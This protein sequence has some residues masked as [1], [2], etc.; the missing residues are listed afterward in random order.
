M[1]L[2]LFISFFILLTHSI[3]YS[4]KLDES[5]TTRIQHVISLFKNPEIDKISDI[6][7]FPLKREHPIPPIRNKQEFKQRF[8]QVFDDNLIRIIANSKIRQWSD[9]GWRGIM[10]DN[11]IIWMA[12]SDGVITSVNYQSD[13][14]EKLKNDLIN[15]EKGDLHS[16]LKNYEKPIYK[17]KTKNYYIRID[18]LPNNE[19]RYASWKIG[20]R[21]SAKPDIVLYKGKLEFQGSGGNHMITFINHKYTYIIF[22]NRIGE[23]PKPDISLIVEKDDEVILSQSGTLVID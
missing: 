20:Q 23:S 18:E 2:K 9:V 3:V 5:K 13:F 15:K 11:G 6:I 14:E 17:I 21:E 7:S 4:Q 10:L 19:F 12:N 1:K 22:R 8:S 16:S